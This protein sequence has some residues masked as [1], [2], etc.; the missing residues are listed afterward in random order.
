MVRDDLQLR[1][2]LEHLR[3]HQARHERAGL[4]RPAEEP[5]DLVLRLLFARIIGELRGARRMHPDRQVVLLR[6]ALENGKELGLVHRPFVHFDEDMNAFRAEHPL[7]AVLLLE[8]DFS[9]VHGQQGD[10]GGKKRRVRLHDLGHAVVREARQRRTLVLIGQEFDRRQR[11]RQHLLVTR[12]ALHHLDALFQIPEHRDVQPAL[13][14][15]GERRLRRGDLLHALE[16][17]GWKDVRKDVQLRLGSLHSSFTPA[18]VASSRQRAASARIT[19][20]KASPASGS[21]TSCPMSITRFLKSAD[22]VTAGTSRVSRSIGSRGVPAG[23]K[24][25]NSAPSTKSPTPASAIV[26]TSGICGERAP[27]VITM[28]FTCAALMRPAAVAMPVTSIS[29]WPETTSA[30]PAPPPLYGTCVRTTLKRLAKSSP[31][32]CGLEPMP[33]EP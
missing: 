7:R 16:E 15:R 5:V 26:G 25:P 1:Q 29:I 10:E 4:V 28:A 31:M 9:S 8:A 21:V 33:G 13:D 23:T 14:V 12:P 30:M 17:G 2:L 11:Q 19:R 32:R 6:H 18:M 27:P 22:C 3:E 20:P 24:T